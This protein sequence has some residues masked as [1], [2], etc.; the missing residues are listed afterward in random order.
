MKYLSRE[1]AEVN[2]HNA[3]LHVRILRLN[4]RSEFRK[5][6]IIESHQDNINSLQSPG[7]TTIQLT[8]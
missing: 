1:L 3:D 8:S 7:Q 4:L 5:D 6:L 2:W